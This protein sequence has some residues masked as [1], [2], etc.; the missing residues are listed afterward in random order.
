V[1]GAR[2]RGDCQCRRLVRN[3]ERA[4]FCFHFLDALT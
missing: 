2:N 4:L 1:I 3:L